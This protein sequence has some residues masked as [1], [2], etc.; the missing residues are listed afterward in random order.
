MAERVFKFHVNVIM[1]G[2]NVD[3]LQ[4]VAAGIGTPLVAGDI[5][6]H[7]MATRKENFGGAALLNRRYFFSRLHQE[8]DVFEE[9]DLNGCLLCSAFHG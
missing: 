8:Y 9:A 6:E 3:T 4:R 7:L 1:D 5:A 2:W